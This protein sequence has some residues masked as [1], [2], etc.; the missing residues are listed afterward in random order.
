[1][2][3]SNINIIKGDIEISADIQDEINKERRIQREEMIATGQV[4]QM[5][6]DLFISL[7]T[8]IGT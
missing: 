5:V 1:M 2:R 6:S 3:T 8:P 7:I 4:D